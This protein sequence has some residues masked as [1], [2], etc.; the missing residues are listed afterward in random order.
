MSFVIEINGEREAR[1][2]GIAMYDRE[3]GGERLYVKETPR[4]SPTPWRHVHPDPDAVGGRGLLKLPLHFD[5]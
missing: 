5:E 4:D 2:V 3:H 1:L